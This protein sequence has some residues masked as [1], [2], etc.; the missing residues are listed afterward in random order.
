[1]MKNEHLYFTCKECGLL[2]P[3]IAEP[4]PGTWSL[5]IWWVHSI[6]YTIQNILIAVTMKVPAVQHRLLYVERTFTNYDCY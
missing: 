3:K 5:L 2:P 1:M 6:H 4:D